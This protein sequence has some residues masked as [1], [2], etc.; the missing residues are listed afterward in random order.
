L[1]VD[2]LPIVDLASDE[3]DAVL[4]NRIVADV[5]AASRD[6]GFFYVVKHGVD[7]ELIVKAFAQS[8]DFFALPVADKRKL[9]IETIG[10]NRGYS[11]LLHEALD[12]ARGPD[13]KEAFNVG[14]ELAADD[15]E[16]LAG[17]PF[18][19]LNAWPGVPGFRETLLSYYDACAG[20]GARLH[21]A[22]AS[23]LGVSRGFFDDKL[24][25][26]WRP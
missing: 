6:V 20:L 9:A 11:G 12:P 25:G 7:P 19:S 23:D 3:S 24:I 26:R 22:F 5:G 2:I 13:M 14:L 21:R 4:L 15:P 8:H 10:G 16:L 17:A 18:R 1:I